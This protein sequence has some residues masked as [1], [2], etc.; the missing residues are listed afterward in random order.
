M[1]TRTPV[2]SPHG[3]AVYFYLDG[4]SDCSHQNAAAV[5]AVAALLQP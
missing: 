1:H 4:D 5:A 3:F 2:I